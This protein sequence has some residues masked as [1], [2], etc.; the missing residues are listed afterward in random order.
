[1]R[2][3]K[4]HRFVLIFT[5]FILTIANANPVIQPG[6]DWSL[7]DWVKAA[8]YIGF[9]HMDRGYS[10]PSIPHIG[11]TFTWQMLNPEEDNYRFDLLEDLISRAESEG[12]GAAIRLKCSVIEVKW[13]GSDP[14]GPFIPQWVLDKHSPETFYTKN[15]SNAHILYAALWDDGVQQEYQKFIQ[16]FGAYVQERNQLGFF[17]DP[18]FLGMYLHAY[19]SSRGEEFYLDPSFD[20]QVVQ[21]GLTPTVLVETL[22]KRMDWWAEA[23][24]EYTYKMAWVGAGRAGVSYDRTKLDQ[25][26][27]GSGFAL[28]GGFIEHYFSAQYDPPNYGFSWNA[29]YVTVDWDHPLRSTKKFYADEYEETDEYPGASGYAKTFST[30]TPYFRAAQMG[31]RFLWV[32]DN[33]IEWAPNIARWYLNVAGKTPA[34]APD[35]VCWLRQASV[36]MKLQGDSDYNTPRPWKNLE[37]LLMQRDLPGAMTVAVDKLQLPYTSWKDRDNTDEYSA[38]RTDVAND[39]SEMVFFLH[40]DF[41]AS[42]EQYTHIKVTYHDESATTWKL[43]A[44]TES[45]VWESSAI[46]GENDGAWKTV[47][48]SVDS[49]IQPGQLRDDCDLLIR[50]TGDADLKV[51]FVRVVKA[52]TALNVGQAEDKSEKSYALMQNYP[53]PFNPTTE[54]AY[55]L[56]EPADV[57]LEIFDVSGRKVDTVYQGMQST[58][59]HRVIW[60]GADRLGNS[61]ATGVYFY[62]LIAVGHSHIFQNTKKMLF[63]K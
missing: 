40:D 22:Q 18:A 3:K 36:R 32:S 34:A 42:I 20:H 29:G 8:E 6:E 21:A 24:G 1:M 4:D 30:Q 45:G 35:A 44:S 63:V 55:S 53:N 14:N 15:S 17:E 11:D 49:P 25:Y 62:R 46:Q 23:A 48:F 33:T 28:R 54:I 2:M 16:A 9:Y 43:M 12:V 39:Q 58:G 37:H 26:A 5:I 38:R 60:N 19:S 52:K 51:R 59:N 61:I 56:P 47:T 27:I 13:A 10:T 7:P 31:M 50:V 57:S 41:R